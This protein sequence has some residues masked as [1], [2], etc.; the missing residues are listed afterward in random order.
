[1]VEFASEFKRDGNNWILFPRDRKDRKSLFFPEKVMKHPAKMNFHLQQA[2]IEYVA[3]KDDVLLDPFG[4]TGTL[5]IAA[6]QG[7]TVVLIEIEEGYHQLQLQ[8][9]EELSKQVPN[10]G[11]LVILLHGDNRLLLPRPCNH[12]ITSPPY[13][14]AMNVK[15]V[16]HFAGQGQNDEM[17]LWMAEQDKRMIE[18]SKSPRNLSKLNQFLYNM[19]MR[20]IY[21]LCYQSL[22]IGGTLTTVIKDRI[23]NGERVYLSK[24]ANKVC[25]AAGFQLELW[26]KWKAPGHAFTNIARSQ[27]KEVVDDEDILIY[28][29]TI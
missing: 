26:E 19:E 27:G 22:P 1:M 10:A 8:A 25:E 7:H 2:I 16:T 21:T 11:N 29:R 17:S 4:G 14:Q 6:L 13:A 18:Y 12:I 3:N 9:K 24:W 20:K 23:V 5:M 15:K 28:R